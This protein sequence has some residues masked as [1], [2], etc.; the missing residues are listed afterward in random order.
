M[1]SRNVLHIVF[2]PLKV[3]DLHDLKYRTGYCLCQYSPSLDFELLCSPKR[4]QDKGRVVHKLNRALYKSL[5][6]APASHFHAAFF[7]VPSGLKIVIA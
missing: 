5:A 1:V 3:R 4:P 2:I 7:H 6:K